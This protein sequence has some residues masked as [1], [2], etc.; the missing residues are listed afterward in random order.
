M[1]NEAFGGP[2]PAYVSSKQAIDF[3]AMVAGTATA[4]VTVEGA[5]P[6]DAVIVVR[7]SVSVVTDAL[8]LEGYCD[9]ADLVDVIVTSNNE[10]A[11]TN[12]ASETLTI[13]VF[14]A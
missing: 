8:M 11:T 13:L 5:K 6:G 9:T 3:G 2:F 1:A 7:P 10:A 4:Q 14:P 12:L